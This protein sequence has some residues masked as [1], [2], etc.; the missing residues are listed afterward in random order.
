MSR[1]LID[2]KPPPISSFRA[3]QQ[4]LRK[5]EIQIFRAFRSNAWDLSLYVNTTKR[6]HPTCVHGPT[7]KSVGDSGKSVAA[8]Q[9][10]GRLRHGRARPGP[11]EWSQ[12][13][14]ESADKPGSVVCRHS[15]GALVAERLM[16]PTRGLCGPHVVLLFGLAPNGVYRAARRCR[17]RGALLPHPFTL[18]RAVGDTSRAVYS[19]LHF[20]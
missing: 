6:L 8:G 11:R 16:R 9:F 7:P 14:R 13:K 12:L 4:V 19:L 17:E 5:L 10:I 2:E 20:P 15:S 18:T 1:Q 3:Y